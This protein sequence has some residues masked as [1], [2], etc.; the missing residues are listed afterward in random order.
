MVSWLCSDVSNLLRVGLRG[1]HGHD[2]ARPGEWRQAQC[3]NILFHSL[4]KGLGALVP[5][6][7]VSK[8]VAE[9]Y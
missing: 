7:L 9:V 1:S 2:G 5:C 8:H 6:L 4:W 3:E